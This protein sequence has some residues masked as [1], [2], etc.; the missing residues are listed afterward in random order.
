MRRMGDY[1]PYTVDDVIA[2]LHE[3]RHLPAS[4]GP[5]IPKPNYVPYALS[6]REQGYAVGCAVKSM[7]KHMTDEG[8]QIFQGLE[9]AG[10]VLHGYGLPY[11]QTHVPDILEY[12]QNEID[13]LVLQ[14]KRE[15]EG[16]TAGPGFD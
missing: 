8:W 1:K 5:P 15:Y 11:P 12:W 16:R 3:S 10:F 4:G 13:T 7:Q 14:D 6:P 9:S 2:G